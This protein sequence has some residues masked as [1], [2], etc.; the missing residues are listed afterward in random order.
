M[1]RLCVNKRRIHQMLNP[2]GDGVDQFHLLIEVLVEKQMQL[3][4]RRP[5]DLP[6]RFLVQIAERHRVQPNRLFEFK[7]E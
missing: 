3:V 7:R 4:E 6:V 1:N 2:L 5:G